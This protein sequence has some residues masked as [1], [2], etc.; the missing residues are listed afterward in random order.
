[1]EKPCHLREQGARSNGASNEQ[2]GTQSDGLGRQRERVR[3]R[4]GQTGCGRMYERALDGLGAPPSTFKTVEAGV[5]RLAGSIPVRLRHLRGRGSEHRSRDQT[6]APRARASTPPATDRQRPRT[7]CPTR[8]ADADARPA[9]TDGP[10]PPPRACRGGG[11]PSARRTVAI[12]G[13][14]HQGPA[15]QPQRRG[16]SAWAAVWLRGADSRRASRAWRHRPHRPSAAGVTDRAS[17]ADM[18]AVVARHRV[19]RRPG[20]RL[21]HRLR[22]PSSARFSIWDSGRR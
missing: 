14:P 13:R 17:R 1:M 18:G 12:P 22:R 6:A 7:P 21:E 2:R 9:R 3:I 15:W 4:A 10:A 19:W 5:P 11:P 8:T 16:R 20:Q